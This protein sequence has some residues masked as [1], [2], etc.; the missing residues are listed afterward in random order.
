MGATEGSWVGD[1]HG[2]IC[3]W[4]ASPSSGVGVA[5]T[6]RC[7][8]TSVLWSLGTSAV[9]GAYLLVHRDRAQQ[10]GA[11]EEQ[12][13]RGQGRVSDFS[14]P[15]R[16]GATCSIRFEPSHTVGCIPTCPLGSSGGYLAH[17]TQ[18]A[19]HKRAK[20]AQNEALAWHLP[21]HCL[22]KPRNEEAC[23]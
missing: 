4:K 20:E 10:V 12:V 3:V 1:W 18:G 8:G 22:K 11:R 5:H 13:G 9:P 16:A 19:E 23:Q 2:G 7:L 17:K 15:P 6:W 21:R 14:V